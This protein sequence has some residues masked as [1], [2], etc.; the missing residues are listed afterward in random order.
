MG[1]SCNW[2]VSL[3]RLVQHL[4]CSLRARLQGAQQLHS[5]LTTPLASYVIL[6]TYVR[7]YLFNKLL[8][9]RTGGGAR[10]L[11]GITQHPLY[12]LKATDTL[13]IFE[14]QQIQHFTITVKVAFQDFPVNL[15]SPIAEICRRIWDGT[16]SPPVSGR[17]RV[18]QSSQA[19]APSTGKGEGLYLPASCVW[20][21]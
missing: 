4:Q 18:V 9:F 13:T 12:L 8:F 17:L 3:S 2:H 15:R 7:R 14:H 20:P 11:Q 16:G 1:L 6:L 5:V 19:S 21:V 10:I